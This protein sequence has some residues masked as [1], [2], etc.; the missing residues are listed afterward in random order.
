MDGGYFI[1]LNGGIPG[2]I[3]AN[4]T[5]LTPQV[6]PMDA[7]GPS[8][9]T[10]PSTGTYFVQLLGIPAYVSKMV[11][12]LKQLDKTFLPKTSLYVDV[13]EPSYSRYLYWDEYYSQKV[14]KAEL[15]EIYEG[16]NWLIG[17]DPDSGSKIATRPMGYINHLDE[18]FSEIESSGLT[19]YTSEYVEEK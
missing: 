4:S 13:A 7:E 8:S 17:W 6:V 15:E 18:A 12:E 1:L 16:I 14:T 5:T 10:L 9:Y 11:Y 3:V 2:I 19:F